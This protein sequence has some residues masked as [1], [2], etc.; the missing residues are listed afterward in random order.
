MKTAKVLAAGALLF[1]ANTAL[2]VPFSYDCTDCPQPIPIGAPGA[3]SGTTT[4]I[5]TV[6]DSATITDL[7]VLFDATHTFD[8][9][10]DIFL[11]HDGVEISLSQDN[12]F[13]GDNFEGT[14]FDDEAATSIVDGDAPFAGSFRPEE[15]LSA[16]DGMDLAG[17]WVLT[18]I[19][20]AGGDFG[21]LITWGIFG[22]A[23]FPSTG[24]PEPG[25]LLLLGAG[26]AGLRFV[27]RS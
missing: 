25:I 17:D 21:E 4:S 19:D 24:V 23:D 7:N 27:R 10:L 15:A 13:D 26:L 14:I 16:F 12:G 11:E 20:D 18:V 3:T 1:A 8:G 9:D 5:I 22:D 6:A 2:A